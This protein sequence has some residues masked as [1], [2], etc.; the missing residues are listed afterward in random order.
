M[1]ALMTK[2]SKATAIVPPGEEEASEHLSII[3]HFKFAT[4]WKGEK[5]G[6]I[7]K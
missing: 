5:R 7:L 1:C 6:W 4:F 2:Y 3:E